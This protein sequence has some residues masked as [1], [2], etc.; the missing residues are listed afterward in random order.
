MRRRDGEAAIAA[1][2]I[3]RIPIP[4]PFPQA[5]GPVNVVVVEEEGGGVAL[6][7]TGLGT[8]EA[9]AFLRRGLEERGLGFEDVRRIFLTHGHID[10]FGLAAEIRDISKAPVRIHPRDRPKVVPPI[11]WIEREA[12]FTEGLLG[13]GAELGAIREMLRAAVRDETMARRLEGEVGDL[14]DGERLVFARCDVTLLEMPGHTPGLV[15]GLAVPRGEAAPAVLLA[16]DHLLEKVS[17]NPVLDFEEDGRR[18]PALT[19]YLRSIGAIREIEI[20]WVIPGHGPCFTGHRRSIDTLL[21]FYER[22]QEKIVSLIPKEGLNAVEL[23]GLLFPKAAAFDTFLI[24]GEVLGNLDVLEERGRVGRVERRG[25]SRYHRDQ[26]TGTS[27][28]R[29]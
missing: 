19:T 8:R 6:F 10:H 29:R 3:H 7:D 27:G 14:H 11:H 1:L 20:E 23:A 26:A 25:V 28:S 4:I 17:P 15:C 21:A 9:A 22:R 2:G 24:L 12:I 18:F 5:G 16:N 13:M